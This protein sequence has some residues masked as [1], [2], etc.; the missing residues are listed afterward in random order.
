[1]KNNIK[2]IFAFSDVSEI[3]Y[4]TMLNYY[5]HIFECFDEVMASFQTGY[6]KPDTQAF[7]HFLKT[8]DVKPEDCIFIDDKEVNVLAARAVGMHA[9]IYNNFVQVEEQLKQLRVF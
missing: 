8:H 3:S 7:Y 9:I 2:K 4:K 5:P 1:M 6:K